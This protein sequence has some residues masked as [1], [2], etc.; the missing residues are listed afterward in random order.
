MKRIF[1]VLCLF[2]LSFSLHAQPEEIT[3]SLFLESI[4]AIK[5]S[6]NQDELY[7]EMMVFRPKKNMEL[8]TIPPRPV[9]WP[10]SVLKNLNHIL[11]WQGPL[12][13]G[14]TVSVVVSLI[15]SDNSIF[16][17]DDFIGSVRLNIKNHQGKLE[18][19]WSLS[20][21]PTITTPMEKNQ[22]FL[23]HNGQTKY[24]VNFSLY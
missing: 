23:L 18:K 10:A 12:K 22:P 1:G 2:W 19:S 21:S 20:N 3:A 15:E 7:F 6:E 16:D 14:E 24:E 9:H 4:K 8:L 11:L 13:E 17:P 5:Q